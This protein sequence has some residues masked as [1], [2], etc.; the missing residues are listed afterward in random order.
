VTK[1]SSDLLMCTRTVPMM[2]IVTAQA[3][4]LGTRRVIFVAGR[5]GFERPFPEIVTA[6][7]FSRSGADRLI[8]ES[9]D[10]KSHCVETV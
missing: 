8:G 5:Q 9:A 7:E 3:I 10:R 2:L 1:P 6:R 4:G